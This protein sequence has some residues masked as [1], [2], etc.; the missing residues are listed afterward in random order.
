MA[1][2]SEKESNRISVRLEL[3]ADF[4]AGVWAHHDNRKFGS[5]EDGDVDE[6][7]AVAS[8]IGDDYLQKKAYGR[9]V[10]DSFNHGT[11]AQRAR[12]L[13][14]GIS[15]GNPADGDTFSISYSQL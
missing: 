12:W 11:S 5:L 15:T 3:Q 13:K 7:L 4:Y 1:R 14:K 9:T 2:V 8:K 10:P 6:G